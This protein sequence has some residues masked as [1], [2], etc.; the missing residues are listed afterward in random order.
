M[1]EKQGQHRLYGGNRG[2]GANRGPAAADPSQA[3]YEFGNELAEGGSLAAYQ[4]LTYGEAGQRTAETQEE[5][6]TT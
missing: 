1:A 5:Q 6:G 2:A 3:T 4:N